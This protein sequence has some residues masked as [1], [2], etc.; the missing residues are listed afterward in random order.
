MQI[1]DSKYHKVWKIEEK[2]GMKF[3]DLGDSKKNK[4]GSYDNFSWFRCM[5]VTNAKQIEL[6]EGDT[7]T[8]ISGIVNKRK[9][10]GKYYDNVVIFD[11]EVTKKAEKKDGVDEDSFEEVTDSSDIPF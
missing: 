8:I 7:I 3:I 1:K 5:L 6:T 10:E 11:L 4:D 9:Y 2:N